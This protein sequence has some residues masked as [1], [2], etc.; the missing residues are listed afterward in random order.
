[1]GGRGGN[2]AH[3]KFYPRIEGRE[4]SAVQVHPAWENKVFLTGLLTLL[5]GGLVKDLIHDMSQ[6][7]S[8]FTLHGEHEQLTAPCQEGTCELSLKDRESAQGKHSLSEEPKK[9]LFSSCPAP[10]ALQCHSLTQQGSAAQFP[11]L[12]QLLWAPL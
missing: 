7:S 11:C 5:K 1:M 12:G 9:P 2:K 6:G 10:Q 3:T 8:E 4:A